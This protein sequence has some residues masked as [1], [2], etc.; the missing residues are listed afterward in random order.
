MS[1][2]KEFMEKGNKILTLNKVE[3]V[4]LF[5]IAVGTAWNLYTGLAIIPYQVQQLQ[6]DNSR[7]EAKIEAQAAKFEAEMKAASER[8][9]ARQELLI[10]MD[11]RLKTVQGALKIPTVQ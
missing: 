2:E 10:R 9:N 5:L 8:E 3:L 7:L 6:K 11:E 4:A 1:A